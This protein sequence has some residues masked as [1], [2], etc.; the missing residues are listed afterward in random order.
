V[1][2]ALLLLIGRATA[3]GRSA[4]ADGERSLSYQAQH[5]SV[6]RPSHA[7]GHY[8]KIFPSGGRLARDEHACVVQIFAPPP[9]ELS[10]RVWVKGWMGILEGIL[11]ERYPVNAC[12][13]VTNEQEVDTNGKRFYRVLADWQISPLGGVQVS[14]KMLIHLRQIK[15][16]TYNLVLTPVLGLREQHRPIIKQMARSFAYAE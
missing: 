7:V 10:P 15:P 4:L 14:G 6:N 16:F 3:P 1:A 12:V 8:Y 5:F 13:T 2:V 9:S 11:Q